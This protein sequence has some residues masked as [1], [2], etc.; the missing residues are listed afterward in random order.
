MEIA[1]LC[2]SARPLLSAAL[3]KQAIVSAP[4]N[5]FQKSSRIHVTKLSWWLLTS[6]LAKITDVLCMTELSVVTNMSLG[7]SKGT[8]RRH[9]STEG[10]ASSNS[11]GVNGV[12]KWA[13][14][15]EFDLVGEHLILLRRH[16]SQY[17][18]NTRRCSEV[19]L[20]TRLSETPGVYP[21]SLPNGS[22]LQPGF[23]TVKAVSGKCKWSLG[24]S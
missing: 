24:V 6:L 15:S 16:L 17:L 2:F 23:R 11:T 9:N 8:H 7:K 14:G 5:T 13:N 1:P 19:F 18:K 12:H 21:I 20:S 4:E 3:P 10:C 22:V